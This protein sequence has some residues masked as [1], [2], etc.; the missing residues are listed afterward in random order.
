[1]RAARYPSRVHSRHADLRRAIVLSVASV[2]WNGLT[3]GSAVIVALST[4]SLA[5]LGF[6]FDAAID[7]IASIALIWRFSAE[8]DQP[9]RA[10]RV[11]RISAAIVGGVLVVLGLYL[12]FEAVRALASRSP[13]ETSAAAVVLLLVSAVVLPPLGIA[14]RRVAKRLDSGALRSDSVLTLVAAL[15]AV[16]GL[17]SAVMTALLGLWWAD[18][19]GGLLVAV[20]LVREGAGGL[21]DVRGRAT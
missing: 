13:H 19:A 14:K 10:E 5:L 2:V 6:G 20:V 3:G 8:R 16:V 17:L 7:S 15:L 12:A 1:V 9:H 11:E 4:G 18:A 21:L